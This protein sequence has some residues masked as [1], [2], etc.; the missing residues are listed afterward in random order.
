M[1][2]EP[3]IWKLSG[4]WRATQDTALIH[5][6]G[7]CVVS[8]QQD[9]RYA[10][11]VN[12]N[13]ETSTHLEYGIWVARNETGLYD[14][15]IMGT[16]VDL[17]GTAKLESIPHVAM[18]NNNDATVCLTVAVFALPEV[19]GARGFLRNEETTYTFEIAIS[20]RQ[21]DVKADNIVEFN[22]RS[23]RS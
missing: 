16:D 11:D 7:E 17:V 5:F 6:E 13:T 9:G 22:P 4:S 14:A 15:T 1:I 10:I 23:R 21:V 2:L 18:L 8:D 3:G 20:P 19:Y 12:A